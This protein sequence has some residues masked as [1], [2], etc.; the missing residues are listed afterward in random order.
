MIE[1]ATRHY[2]L[3]SANFAKQPTI[4]RRLGGYSSV[5]YGGAALGYAASVGVGPR[6]EATGYRGVRVKELVLVCDAAL[7]VRGADE[8]VAT[9]AGANLGGLHYGDNIGGG[10]MPTSKKDLALSS[11]GFSSNCLTRVR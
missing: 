7:L 11:I 8:L 6:G 9:K 4:A 1:K 2:N 10:F 3:T 5:A